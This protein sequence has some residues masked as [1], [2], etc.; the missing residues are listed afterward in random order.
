MN[1]EWSNIPNTCAREWYRRPNERAR[2]LEQ[3]DDGPP[4]GN[5]QPKTPEG[6]PVR[7]PPPH[8]V[9]DGELLETFE[10]LP[11]RGQ[12]AAAAAAGMTREQA[13]AYLHQLSARTA[14]M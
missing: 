9:L 3:F 5:W 11:W 4:P 13:L 1:G 2:E 7:T 8:F 14:F 10:H 12:A 6:Q